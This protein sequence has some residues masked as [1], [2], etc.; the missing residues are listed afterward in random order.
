MFNNPEQ[1]QA[2]KSAVFLD[3]KCSTRERE[4]AF[5]SPPKLVFVIKL[6]WQWAEFYLLPTFKYKDIQQHKTSDTIDI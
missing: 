2:L 6:S 1:S 4:N 5:S 3:M